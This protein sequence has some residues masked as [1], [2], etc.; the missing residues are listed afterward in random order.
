MSGFGFA[1][2]IAFI[3]YLNNWLIVVARLRFDLQAGYRRT[4]LILYTFIGLVAH[5]S[6]IALAMHQQDQWVF[7]FG[8][9]LSLIGWSAAAALWIGM[10]T[11]PT[12]MLGLIIFPFAALL[13]LA[14]LVITHTHPLPME[15]GAHIVLAILAYGLFFLAATQAILF[16]IQEKRF[17]AHQLGRLF[18]ALPPL[19]L[20][21][22]TLYQLLILGFITLTFA[23]ITGF[24]FVD[25]LFAQHLVHKTFFSLL[26]WLLYGLLLWGHFRRGWRG[27]KAARLT[28]W[29]FVLLMLGYVG[30]TFVLEFLLHR[31]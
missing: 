14:P 5:A 1:S 11:K 20:M 9:A 7:G 3:L 15:Y 4:Q 6:S 10:L 17:R 19:Q 12:E 18:G 28:L 8:I 25:D 27:R 23:L 22:K 21:E 30:S 24:F 13:T 2:L 16:L 26:A 29:A 31:P